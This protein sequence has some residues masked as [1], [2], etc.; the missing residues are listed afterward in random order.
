M[1]WNYRVNLSFL[2]E[3]VLIRK[4]WNGILVITLSFCLFGEA[5]AKPLSGKALDQ[6]ILSA[7]AF[8]GDEEFSFPSEEWQTAESLQELENLAKVKSRKIASSLNESDMSPAYRKFVDEWTSLTTTK[9]LDALLVRYDNDAT[10]QELPVDLR[11]VVSQLLP[12]R[13]FRGF[14][15]RL[16]P[17][18]M[19]AKVTDS[20]LVTWAKGIAG[21]VASL[22]PETH[23]QVVFR[24]FTEPFESDIGTIRTEADLQRFLRTSVYS[25]V[26]KMVSRIHPAALKFSDH[27]GR[28]LVWDNRLIFGKSSFPNQGEERF[29][30][31]G[32]AERLAILSIAHANLY[33]IVFFNSFEWK[34][35]MALTKDYGRLVGFDSLGS[36]VHGL[37]ARK[38]YELLSRYSR[39]GSSWD[40]KNPKFLD[41]RCENSKDGKNEQ[42]LD[43]AF[44]HLKESVNYAA[45]VFEITKKE[46]SDVMKIMDPGIFKPFLRTN[47]LAISLQKRMVNEGVAEVRSNVTGKTVTVN[48]NA[49]F[50]TNPPQSLAQF[51]PVFLD[52]EEPEYKTEM[53]GGRKITFRNF[54]ANRAKRWNESSFSPFIQGGQNVEEKARIL[55]QAWGGWLVGMPLLLVF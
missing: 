28:Y 43:L 3:V 39:T 23:N 42:C 38:R 31:F 12:L 36:E 37:S 25:A 29:R 54:S 1:C 27:T 17:L 45:A 50:L 40:L 6:A 2:G 24:Y 41:R 14:V 16:R 4:N 19:Q 48:L 53:R 55:N 34:G 44:R 18:A 26:R 32:E 30:H 7:P 5:L 13:A 47:E 51:A 21:G 52:A 10:F 20:M 15:Y 46:P 35:M 33:S 49:F 22:M 8:S 9:E 11:M